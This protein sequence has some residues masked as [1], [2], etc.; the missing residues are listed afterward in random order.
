MSGTDARSRF[1]RRLLPVMVLGA[2]LNPINSSIVAVALVPI[3]RALDAPASQTAWLVSGLYLAT[4]IGQPVVGRLVDVLGPRRLSLAGA[5]LIGLGGLIG[6]LAPNLPVLVVARVV[7]G[8]GTCAG[9]PAAM[10]L[11]RSEAR[12]TGEESPQSVL[13]VLAV[14]SQ[15]IAVVGPTLGGL[16]IGVGGWRATFAVNLP[17]AVVTFVLAWLRMPRGTITPP[18]AARPSYDLPGVALFSGTLIALLLFL[19]EPSLDDTW[20]LLLTVVLAVLFAVREL[21]A[22]DPFLDVRVL[23][24]SPALLA[25]YLRQLLTGITAYSVL[26]GVTQWLQDGRGLSP[27]QAGA[28]LLPLSGTAL[29]VSALTGRRAEIRA[30][31]VVGACAQLLGSMLLLLLDGA[32]PVWFLVVL[33]VVFGVPQGLLN[34]GNQNAVYH[35]AEASRIASSAGL[36]RTGMY[37]GAIAS[38]A[39][40]GAFFG[41]SADTPGL[42]Q[43]AWFLVVVSGLMT[44]L[45]LADRSLRAVGVR[46]DES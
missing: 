19:M 23:G 34:L 18:T 46:H 38:S 14:S 10:Y 31:L 42:H 2:V 37:L 6:T 9:Y 39:A 7:L 32:T 22:S 26:Y 4:S 11:I 25:T 43:L 29:V 35:Q 15:T 36:L 33:I 21:R 40:A 30:K 12:R 1:D 45:T 13:T 16:L 3:G 41:P 5:V 8:L 20:L 28:L 17:L 44:L 27:S 24:H